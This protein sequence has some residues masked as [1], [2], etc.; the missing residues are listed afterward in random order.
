LAGPRSGFLPALDHFWNAF[1]SRDPRLVLVICGSAASWMIAKVIDH[2]GG[3]HNRVTA[4]MKLEPFTL[5]E[6]SRFL[7]SRGVK[8]TRYDQIMLAMVMGGVPHYL[9]EARPGEFAVSSSGFT[10]RCLSIRNVM[11]SWCGSWR[12]IL[13]GSRAPP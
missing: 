11:W 3:L 7:E 5:A 4:R 1:A 12:S 8:L 10:R 6:S 9:K 13:S 2:K